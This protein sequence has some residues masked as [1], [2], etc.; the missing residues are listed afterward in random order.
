VLACRV[1][2]AV[3]LRPGVRA[4]PWWVGW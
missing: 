3:A 4:V 2:E 1:E